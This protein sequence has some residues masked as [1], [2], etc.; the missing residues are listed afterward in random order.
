[1]IALVVT[2]WLVFSA[3]LSGL[4]L[5]PIISSDAAVVGRWEA[6]YHPTV[7]L[8]ANHRFRLVERGSDVGGS[9][10][11]DD[12]N[13]FLAFDSGS[14]RQMRFIEDG[15]RIRLL[16]NPPSDWDAWNGDLGLTRR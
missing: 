15:D 13:L 4:E 9:W 6:A 2:N 3:Q 12:W 11:R 16:N 10:Q 1:M 5:N 7:I 8:Q 14:R